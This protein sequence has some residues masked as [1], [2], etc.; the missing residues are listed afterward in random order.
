MNIL[1]YQFVL[2][3]NRWHT[4]A[5][6]RFSTFAI[7]NIAEHFAHNSVIKTTT[8]KQHLKKVS[9]N[10]NNNGEDIEKK[11][12]FYALG[13]ALVAS[14]FVITLITFVDD[15]KTRLMFASY[16]P[17][18][19]ETGTVMLSSWLLLWASGKFRQQLINDFAIIR[20]RNNRVGTIERP[21][22]NNHRAVGGAVVHQLQ[23]RFQFRTTK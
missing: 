7:V 19:M 12:L 8:Y 13:H 21:R 22:N 1:F 16:Y 10:G 4:E 14:Q 9:I 20:I 11:L 18:I 5:V 2:F 3:C 6:L 17:L 23:T 15:L